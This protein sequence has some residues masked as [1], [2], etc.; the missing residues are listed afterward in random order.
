MSLREVFQDATKNFAKKKFQA[1]HR[2]LDG[3]EE[4][5]RQIEDQAF[6]HEHAE[7]PSYGYPSWPKAVWV[8]GNV[9]GFILLL[10][11]TGATESSVES[12]GFYEILSVLFIGFN[13]LMYIISW[14]VNSSVSRRNEPWRKWK[15]I[16]LGRNVLAKKFHREAKAILDHAWVIIDREQREIRERKEAERARRRPVAL[17]TCTF[18]QAEKLAA[19]W[20]RHLG[21]SDAA[22]TQ[23]TRDGGIDVESAT[24]V[25]E[26]KHRSVPTGPSFVREIFGVA[27]AKRKRAAFFSQGGY[28][29]DATRF[30]RETGV[31]LFVYDAMRGTLTGVT[32]E[33]RRA[34]AEGLAD[35]GNSSR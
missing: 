18:Q 8:I 19:Q 21:A 9:L 15:E 13:A 34:I 23:A 2:T 5:S 6:P 4:A 17:E 26:V 27:Q 10:V 1:G 30:G 28:T 35:E 14:A 3:W 20:M 12:D 29:K 25:V 24:F 16:E 32:P 11:G 22:V 31:L 33:S 7:P